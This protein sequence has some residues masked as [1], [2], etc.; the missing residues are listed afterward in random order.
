MHENGL[1]NPSS[2]P[3]PRLIDISKRLESVPEFGE[4][5]NQ[6]AWV[7]VEDGKT[8]SFTKSFSPCTAPD[9]D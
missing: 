2:M 3:I 9:D 6:K 4:G 7:H 5:R 8:M 1:A